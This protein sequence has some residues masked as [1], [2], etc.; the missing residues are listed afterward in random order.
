MPQD[1]ILLMGL[2]AILYL[3][4]SALLLY[5][6]EGVLLPARRGRW[7]VDLGSRHFQ[8]FGKHVFLPNPLLPHRPVFKLSWQLGGDGDA[9]VHEDWDALRKAAQPIAPM[10]WLMAVALF[11]LLPLGFLTALG[12]GVLLAALILLYSSVIA[13]LAWIWR[14]RRAFGLGGKAFAAL[15]FESLVCTPLALNL[16]RKLAARTAAQED[17][18]SASRRLQGAED[19]RATAALL[20]VRLDEAIEGEDESSTRMAELREQRRRILDE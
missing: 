15:A 4:D 14:N 11:V 13:A 2:I 20:V 16:A 9:V 17:L 19:W 18:V 7:L 5:R 10:I 12:D 3:C 8:V 6:N 1:A